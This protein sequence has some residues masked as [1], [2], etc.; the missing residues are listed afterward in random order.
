MMNEDLYNNLS[1]LDND[2]LRERII[3]G[4]LTQEASEVACSIL[5]ERQVE[6]PVPVN[7]DTK[8]INDGSFFKSL[9]RSSKNHPY[10]SF[11][12]TIV[13]LTMISKVIRY[14]LN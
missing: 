4:G 12:F 10:L 5:R 6:I 2:D 9:K 8:T 3:G 1:K 11:F 7:Y 13:I 14:F